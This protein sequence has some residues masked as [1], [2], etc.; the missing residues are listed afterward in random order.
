MKSKATIGLLIV[1]LVVVGIISVYAVTSSNPKMTTIGVA[2]WGGNPEFDRSIEGFKRGLANKGYI[3][4]EN[5]RFIVKNPEADLAKQHEI[6][7]YFVQE[8]VDLIYSLTTPGTIVAKEI[9]NQMSSPIPV[10]FSICTYPVESGLIASLENSGNNLVGTRNYVPFSQQY[11][12]FEQLFGGIQTLAVVRRK[13]ESNST[14]QFEEIKTQ[15]E[16]RGIRIIDIAAVDLDDIRRQLEEH[17]ERIDALYSTCDTLTHG[18]GEDIIV[19]F[20]KRHKKPSFACNKEG[21]QKGH[22]VGNV[23]D[24]QAIAE[25]SGEQAALILEG[26]KPS[27]LKTESPREDYIV[28]N[29]TT[30]DVLGISLSETFLERVKEVQ[31]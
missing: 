23:G 5:I 2:R 17:I 25:I 22:L 13:D 24:F 16:E 19:E 12:A 28:I 20:S 8:K 9:T 11:Y 4:E 18:G 31:R 7:S 6:I 10:V 30:A 27:W 21:V 15:F 26:A 29:Q 1:S 3:E 14:N